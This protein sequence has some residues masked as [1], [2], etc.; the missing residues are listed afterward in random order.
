[1]R[2]SKMLAW[3][4]RNIPQQVLCFLFIVV[5]PYLADASTLSTKVANMQP[6]TWTTLNTDNDGSGCCR[7]LLEV[8]PSGE[9]LQW[10]NKG[11]WDPIT[12]QVLFIGQAHY[13]LQKFVGYTESSNA[14]VV[15]PQPYWDCSASAPSGSCIGHGNDHNA[16]DVAHRHFYYRMYGSDKI[17]RYNI[18]TGVWEQIPSPASVFGVSPSALN[19]TAGID[20]FPEMDGLIYADA[21]WGIAIYRRASNT[22]QRI[23]NTNTAALN[24][25]SLPTVNMG[26]GYLAFAVYNP[27]RR[28]VWIGGSGQTRSYTLDG[29]G[30]FTQEATAPAPFGIAQSLNTVDPVSGDFLVLFDGGTFYKYNSATK[31]WSQLPSPTVPIFGGGDSADST[32][33]FGKIVIPISSYGV[34]MVVRYDFSN[35]AVYLYKHTTGTGSTPPPP[36]A[37]TSPPSTPTNVIGSALSSSQINVL[38][39]A[40]TDNV[41]V[42]GYTIFRNGAQVGNVTS[43]SYTDSGLNPST[44]YSYT[45]RA[46]DAAGNTSPQSSSVTVTTLAG[47]AGGTD[48]QSRCSAAGVIRCV[49]FDSTADISGSWGN[50]PTGILPGSL[51]KPTIDT[52]MKASGN[53]SLLFVIPSNSGGDSSGSY[54]ANF[55]NDLSVQFGQG[56][57]FYV[58]WRQ[59]FDSNFLNTIY[60]LTTGEG[61]WKQAIVGAGST[62]GKPQASCTILEIVMQNTAQKGLPQGYHACGYYQPFLEFLAPSDWKIQNAIPSPYCLS[63]NN[64]NGQT[65]GKPPCFPY[66]ANEWMTFQIHVKIGNW[67]QPN[68]RIEFWAAREG[69]PSVKI[70]DMQNYTLCFN[71]TTCASENLKYGQVWLLPYHTNKDPSQTHPVG[72]I[73]YDELIISRNKIVDPGVPATDSQPPAPPANLRIM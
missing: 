71:D 39:S 27:V 1:M 65:Q 17:F 63:A 10:M 26:S 36:A 28:V 24:D 4:L 2:P 72:H 67:N 66:Y 32:D 44:T 18:D 73:W 20:Y 49:G 35:S 52:S 69:Q 7:S 59:R 60:Q 11:T 57:E 8:S 48:F 13:A 68:S 40:S 56:E 21:D 54:F 37:D 22:W 70:I 42:A 38:W 14:W 53:G 41:G 12:R 3:L 9:I 62:P 51:T 5:S 30:A 15:K 31:V 19:V 50:N 58:Q 16:I 33:V 34:V 6:G 45:V 46:Y 25:P 61:G 47:V 43:T 55:S 29:S 23:A 64:P